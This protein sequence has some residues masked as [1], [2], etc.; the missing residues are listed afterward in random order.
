MSVSPANLSGSVGYPRNAKETEKKSQILLL[1]DVVVD[2]F[3]DLFVS[4]LL[5]KAVD[6]VFYSL[7]EFLTFLV[8]EDRGIA[9]VGNG[10]VMVLSP[11]AVDESLQ[12]FFEGRL[13]L[14][15]DD[16]KSPDVVIA[17]E[18]LR[19]AFEGKG[20]FPCHLHGHREGSSFKPVYRDSCYTGL[21]SEFLLRQ[22]GFAS[23]FLQIVHIRISFRNIL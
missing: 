5:I 10:T 7:I 15:L 1:H 18:I 20:Q 21:F 19:F 2:F 4:I 12:G 23:V 22:S 9:C 11:V 17:D 3:K 16:E 6:E 14:V 13:L 8:I